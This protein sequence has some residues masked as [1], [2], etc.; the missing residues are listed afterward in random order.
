M[1]A[2]ST[3]AGMAVIVSLS[4]GPALA[5]VC[6]GKSMSLDEII[7]TIN[8]TPGCD[9]AMKLFE[10][11]EYRHQRRSPSWRR[12]R[13]EMRTRFP[14]PLQGAAKAGL[15]T[16]DAGLRPKVPKP[17]RYHVPFVHSVLPGGGRP[18]LLAPGAESRALAVV[19]LACRAYAASAALAFSA[20]AWNAAGSVIARSDST[21]RSTVMPDLERPSINRL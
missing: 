15:S 19:P 8:A 11:C 2:K 7:D 13:K 3:L 10:A 16:R 6:L 20:I 18:A 14:Q 4:A 1:I 17:V 21:L 5:G 12:R 9:R